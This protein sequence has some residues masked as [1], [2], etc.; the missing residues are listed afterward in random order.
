MLAFFV[1]FSQS[2]DALQESYM[3]C[4]AKRDIAPWGAV[5]CLVTEAFFLQKKFLIFPPDPKSGDFLYILHY[6]RQE[7]TADFLPITILTKA[8]KCVIL[9]SERNPEPF[10]TCRGR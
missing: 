7:P 6:V 5:I 1:I 8:K 3:L 9:F 4:L 10:I 2:A